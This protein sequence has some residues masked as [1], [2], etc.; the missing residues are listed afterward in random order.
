MQKNA[1][2]I[3]GM[4]KSK[5]RRSIDPTPSHLRSLPAGEQHTNS[6]GSCCAHV[7]CSPANCSLLSG[8]STK[9]IN[10]ACAQR[11]H[12]ARP[13]VPSNASSAQ[14]QTGEQHIAN[15][16]VKPARHVRW[17]QPCNCSRAANGPYA[18]PHAQRASNT[19]HSPKQ[20]PA[21]TSLPACNS[22][23]QR[24]IKPLGQSATTH[25]QQRQQHLHHLG[26]IRFANQAAAA[27]PQQ[28]ACPAPACHTQ[29]TPALL[30]HMQHQ[31]ATPHRAS[32]LSRSSSSSPPAAA[33]VAM[34]W[35]AAIGTI[36]NA[37]ACCTP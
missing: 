13:R 33:A 28:H 37:A 32:R 10:N 9:C 6:S 7:V 31:P 30:L 27:Q 19:N 22:T 1:V 15:W 17:L 14:T 24:S 2:K 5:V 20:V 35:P 21:S 25:T 8:H 23:Q 26:Q 36:P 34:P 29:H 11:A 18:R 12:T 16:Q 4:R 3:A